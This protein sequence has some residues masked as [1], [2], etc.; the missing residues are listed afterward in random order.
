[1]VSDAIPLLSLVSG[2]I[3][4]SRLDQTTRDAAAHLKDQLEH[5][6]APTLGV[7]VNGIAASDGFYG[8]GYAY[9][10]GDGANGSHPEPAAL[11]EPVGG[12]RPG[13]TSV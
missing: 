11:L 10:E 6:H 8:Y 3:V 2:V 9:G 7:V 12:G 5:L 13:R 4:V 1:V